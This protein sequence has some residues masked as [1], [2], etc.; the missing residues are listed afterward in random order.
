M[1]DCKVYF[2]PKGFSDEAHIGSLEE[3]KRLHEKSIQNPAQFW[4]NIAKDYY[5][6]RP[7]PE[8]KALEYN[9]DVNEGDVYVRWF[10]EGQ[11]NICYNALD[12]HVEAGKGDRIA[13]YWQGNDPEDQKR[14]TYKELL[15]QVCVFGSSLRRIGVGKGDRVA[16]YMPMVLELIVAVLACARIGAVHSVV[17]GGF[18]EEALAGRIIDSKASVL[19][20]C[21]GSWR[22]TKLVNLKAI[23]NEALQ[24]CSARGFTV[25]SCIVLRHLSIPPTRKRSLSES[26]KRDSTKL[27]ADG[28]RPAIDFKVDMTP[29]RDIWWNDFISGISKTDC[30][31]QW[32][33]AEDMLFVLYTSGSTGKPK[34]MV[35]TVGGYMI[36]AGTT[37][38]Y[39]FD[40]HDDDVYWCTAD[41]GWITGHTY[42]IYGPLL[43]GATGVSFE[44][45]PTWPDNGRYWKIIE[46]LGV[47]KFYTAPTVIRLLIKAG[48]EY[49]KAYNRSTLKVLGT[50]G[51]PINSATWDWYYH[52][53]G[54]SRCSVID[55]YWQTE[56][57]GHVLTPL[58]GATPMKPG[59]AGMPFFGIDAK[60]IH[61]D[62]D[63]VE[64]PSNNVNGCGQKPIEFSDEGYLVITQP[65][66]G[67][68]RTIYGDHKRYEDV[69]FR[70]FPGCYM[71]GDGAHKDADGHFWITGRIDDMLNV[72]GHLLSTSEVES[73]LVS[74]SA[75]A[76]AAAVSCPH[77]IKGECLYCFVTFKDGIH[78]LTATLR[79]D[80]VNLVRH[81]IGAFATPDFIQEANILPKTRSGKIIRRILRKVAVGDRNVGDSSTLADPDCL[82]FLF[83]EAA[84]LRA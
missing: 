49:V 61:E 66:P 82:E 62:S 72:S 6:S 64:V 4:T 17:F 32:M 69:Y 13:F 16:I 55:T 11:T 58:P 31:V 51:E 35:H 63:S 56:T 78:G 81:R 54:E 3:Y 27:P 65:W 26:M 79:K 73:A 30:E 21:D 46:E 44:G 5:W 60:L 10:S 77:A 38:R 74:H 33:D 43:N 80:L 29:N 25:E 84:K 47:T 7:P 59:S 20:T 39:A 45:I 71:T 22:A 8:S 23:V 15:S 28:I 14:I 37:F 19:V 24:L 67:I 68:A 40:H 18:S 2:P 12:R 70:K 75:V 53:V 9:F 41:V 50:V 42:L 48:D 34:G 52:V 1:S 57:G 83:A 76:E 36:Y